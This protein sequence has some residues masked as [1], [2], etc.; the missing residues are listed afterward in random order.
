MEL[1]EYLDVLLN[2]PEKCKSL[3]FIN[4]LLGS[5]KGSFSASLTLEL[6]SKPLL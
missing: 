2:E 5:L 1:T 4:P 3:K 6:Y